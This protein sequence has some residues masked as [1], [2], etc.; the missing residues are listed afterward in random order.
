VGYRQLWLHLDGEWDLEMAVE[1][2]MTATRQLA[3]RQMTWLRSEEDL[4]WLVSD[5]PKNLERVIAA[6]GSK[7]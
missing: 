4:Q 2:S 5:D 1:K 7:C 3:K 6:I